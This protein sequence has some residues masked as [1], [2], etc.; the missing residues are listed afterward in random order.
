MND[1]AQNNSPEASEDNNQAPEQEQQAAPE[2]Q[3]APSDEAQ[4]LAQQQAEELLQSIGAEPA[5]QSAPA[6]PSAE[7]ELGRKLS[8]LNDQLMRAVAE[9]ENVRKRAQRDLEEANKYAVSGMARELISVME[10]LRRASD[11]IPEEQRSNNEQLNNLAIGVDMT[12]SELSRVFEKFGIKRVDPMGE[13]FDH[14][15]HQAVAQIDDPN[16]EAGTVLQVLQAGYV[17]HDRLLQPAMVGV[18][19]K[20]GEPQKQVDTEA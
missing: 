1:A 14:N 15:F 10:N 6:A 19:S 11:S 12:L 18:A 7:E 13:K 8:D 5:A 4:N 17:I 2:Q 20:N 16:A 9:T 3:D